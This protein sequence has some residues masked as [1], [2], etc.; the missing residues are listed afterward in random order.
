MG[1][2]CEIAFCRANVPRWGGVS[3]ESLSATDGQMFVSAAG[4]SV[5][6]IHTKHPEALVGF[7]VGGRCI[8]SVFDSVI[9]LPSVSGGVSVPVISAFKNTIRWLQ[10]HLMSAYWAIYHWCQP[11]PQVQHQ[12]SVYY[13]DSMIAKSFTLR[14]SL[15]SWGEAPLFVLEETLQIQMGKKSPLIVFVCSVTD[16]STSSQK[17]FKYEINIGTALKTQCTQPATRHMDIVRATTAGAFTSWKPVISL[18]SSKP[19]LKES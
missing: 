15:N 1:S 11:I 4:R 3:E 13:N 8:D 6:L 10:L 7:L 19:E 17:D 12:G 16:E 5:T 18:R 2:R 14:V 9:S